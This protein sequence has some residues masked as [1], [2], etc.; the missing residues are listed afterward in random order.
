MAHGQPHLT[1]RGNV[2]WFSRRLPGPRQDSAKN[3]FL[4]FSLRTD[5]PCMARLRARRLTSLTD[6]AAALLESSGQVMTS[7]T[8]ARVL[9]ELARFEIAAADQVRLSAPLRSHAEAEAAFAREAAIR[10]T[11]REAFLL[12]DREVV[13]APLLA[14][15]RRLGVD[16]PGCPADWHGLADQAIRVLVEVSE[17]RE[18]RDRG[19]F[20][21]RSGYVT[22]A[23]ETL[24]A[25][26]PTRSAPPAFPARLAPLPLDAFALTETVPVDTTGPVTRPDPVTSCR[27]PAESCS[28][29][30]TS[31]AADLTE[32]AS[33]APVPDR[34]ATPRRAAAAPVRRATTA[35]GPVDPAGHGIAAP[36]LDSERS[37]ESGASP[38]PQDTGA[39][40]ISRL[41][42][43]F[44]ALRRQGYTR[45][46]PTDTP[47]PGL[48][49][50]WEK[51]SMGNAEST[52]KLMRNLIGDRDICEVS[53]E[54]LKEMKQILHRIPANHGKSR[55]DPLPVRTAVDR[56]DQSEKEAMA[57]CE[58]ELRRE[59][60][61]RGKIE[62]AVHECRVARLRVNTVIRH[63]REFSR[64]LDCAVERG[65]LVQNPLAPLMYSEQDIKKMILQESANARMPWGDRIAALNGSPIFQEQLEDIGDPLYWAPLIAQHQ[66][67]REEEILQ[68]HVVNFRSDQGVAFIHITNGPGQS[69]KTA[70]AHRS[71]PIHRN[72][73]ALGLM[74]L[75]EL[76]RR[77]GETHLFPNL[78]RGKTKDKFSENF[79]KRF[80]Y[81]RKTN[82]CYFTDC[83][84]HS[85]RTEFNSR[86]VAAGVQDTVRR[87]LMGHDENEVGI[88]HYL[89]MGFPMTLLRDV[90][91]AIDIDIS[92]IRRP[93]ERADA[94]PKAANLR[95]IRGG[96][97]SA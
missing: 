10:E 78:T 5:I 41:F 48:G 40:R 2:F 4:R 56:A 45:F 73:L 35:V 82:G 34:A 96:S 95:L 44:I 47:V 46:R 23:I 89:P 14:V 42:D 72:L 62:A 11:L 58:A 84:F 66:G 20:D 94:A 33:V 77:Q 74:D 86:L 21:T 37:G 61:S 1:R 24:E 67:M 92:A 31:A 79:T 26:A 97:A 83:D 17:A 13:R 88:R 25:R 32:T 70:A 30:E 91:D 53:L 60:A 71:L 87:Y 6:Y 55:K 51:N 52:Q 43:D 63:L 3:A 15:C 68:L 9:T 27:A 59:G 76:R 54:E 39:R 69:L 8:I 18:A 28:G 65:V 75:V 64:V 85:F 50:T 12:R 49:K 38:A 90:V 22:A 57:R 93:F 80:T 29:P 36:R 19:E 16:L 81:Y 7:S